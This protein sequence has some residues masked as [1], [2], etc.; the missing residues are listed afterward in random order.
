M[1]TRALRRGNGRRSAID[2]TISATMP[3]GTLIVKIQRQPMWSVM[4]P[5]ARGPM[6]PAEANTAMK[7]A[8]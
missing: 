4:N 2:V 6:T 5:P 8:M 7:Y 3:M 1:S